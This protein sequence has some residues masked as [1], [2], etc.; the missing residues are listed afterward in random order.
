MK[1]IKRTV[2]DRLPKWLHSNILSAVDFIWQGK[3]ES[4]EESLKRVAAV[5]K[6]LT[7]EEM[8]WVMML[9]ILPKIKEM[10]KTSDDFKDYKAMKKASV[11]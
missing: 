6:H 3:K 7:D 2:D 8:H 4:M 5:D 10:L 9:L 11:H 1:Q